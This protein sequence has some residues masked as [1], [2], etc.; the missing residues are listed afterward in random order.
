MRSR[1]LKDLKA[2]MHAYGNLI[3]RTNGIA[4]LEIM[5]KAWEGSQTS[6]TTLTEYLVDQ[7]QNSRRDKTL[8]N[9][10]DIETDKV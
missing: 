4:I 6:N 3:A 8:L 9:C 2:R 10:N 5:Q 1:L 7:N